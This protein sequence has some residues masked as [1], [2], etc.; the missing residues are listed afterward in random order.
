MWEGLFTHSFLRVHAV[1]EITHCYR[2]LTGPFIRM[3]I[4]AFL[5][6]FLNVSGQYDQA[7]MTFDHTVNKKLF[8]TLYMYNKY[9][10]HLIITF[11]GPWFNGVCWILS[12]CTV[13]VNSPQ[14]LTLASTVHTCIHADWAMDTVLLEYFAGEKLLQMS[15][16]SRKFDPL[17]SNYCVLA[18]IVCIY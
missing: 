11:E 6:V 16:I 13:P 14:L 3:T 18:R 1:L 5:Y 12:T 8:L 15:Q 4:H 9:G 17:G 10:F 7:Q 2:S